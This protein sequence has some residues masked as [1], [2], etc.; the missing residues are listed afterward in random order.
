MT[1]FVK[2]IFAS[3][4][5]V[6]LSGCSNAQGKPQLEPVASPQVEIKM[7]TAPNGYRKPSAAV[8]ISHN[9]SGRS[10]IGV[11]ENVTFQISDGYP[12]GDLSL[13][14]FPSDGIQ[15]FNNGGLQ[16]I[17][18]KLDGDNLNE[19]DVQFQAKEEGIHQITLIATVITRDGQLARR[20]YSMPIYVGDQFQKPK[21]SYENKPYK[22][23]GKISDGLIIMDA[24]ETII[25]ED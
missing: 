23:P 3:S 9:F 21:E 16:E 8:R 11:T 22:S 13:E 1:N 19:I 10:A 6:L 17:A 7:N 18:L 14:V 15:M 5:L 25:V 2:G 20:S 4:L 24:E 12:S